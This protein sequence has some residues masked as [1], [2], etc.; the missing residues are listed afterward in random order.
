MSIVGMGVEFN[1]ALTETVT[2]NRGSLYSSA[3]SLEE[4]RQIVVDDFPFNSF[5]AA[6]DVNLSIRS[7]ATSFLFWMRCCCHGMPWCHTRM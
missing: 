4:L 6:F 7:G 5:P 1:A 2:K 3:T